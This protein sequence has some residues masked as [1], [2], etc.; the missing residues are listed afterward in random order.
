MKHTYKVTGMTCGGC[1]ASVEKEL[2][3][4]SG[5][6]DVFVDLEKAEAEVTM[7]HHIDTVTLKSALSD[8]YELSEKKERNVFASTS[9]ALPEEEKSKWQQ[10]TPS[11]L[12]AV[13]M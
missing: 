4:V 7:D 1:V 13:Q 5:V 12:M 8:K 9:S 3:K 10:L 6:T 11:F 2:Q